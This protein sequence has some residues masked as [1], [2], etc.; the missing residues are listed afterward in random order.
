MKVFSLRETYLLSSDYL[1]DEP[2][3]L[4]RVALHGIVRS[5]SVLK[6]RIASTMSRASTQEIKIAGNRKSPTLRLLRSAG[7]VF[8]Y[9]LS[10]FQFNNDV[11]VFI[12]LQGHVFDVL[13]IELPSFCRRLYSCAGCLFCTEAE[14]I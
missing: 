2:P 5:Q 8:G 13:F 1:D 11:A 6:S 9:R 3:S 4:F 12:N 7:G 14:V 10:S